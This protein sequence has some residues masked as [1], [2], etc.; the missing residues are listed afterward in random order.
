MTTTLASL[1]RAAQLMPGRNDVH[2]VGEE[3]KRHLVTAT[4]LIETYTG[5]TYDAASQTIVMDSI[6]TLGATSGMSSTEFNKQ[7]YPEYVL[8]VEGAL[9]SLVV[10]DRAEFTYDEE[11]NWDDVDPLVTPDNY[12]YDEDTGTVRLRYR[13]SS[14]VHGMQFSFTKGFAGTSEMLAGQEVLN[15]LS[16]SG[17]DTNLSTP[18]RMLAGVKAKEASDSAS[19]AVGAA[20]AV[21]ITLQPGRET[22]L[23]GLFVY[24]PQDAP[25]VDGDQEFIMTLIGISAGS[26]DTTLSTVTVTTP[27]ALQQFYL[28]GDGDT[29]YEQYRV[30]ISAASPANVIVSYVEYEFA[31]ADQRHMQDTAP[32]NL[33]EACAMLA[34]QLYTR[35]EGGSTGTDE[36]GDRVAVSP[37]TP[38]IRQMLKPYR[39]SGITLV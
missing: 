39:S 35:N 18:G 38:E 17:L 7:P 26:Q 20:E 32:R 36:D 5:K 21:Y 19:V 23:K 24:A 4:M 10:K 13:Q 27:L 2:S 37:M 6:A 3:M 15:L 16:L 8:P 30:T 31:D 1:T 14:R 22:A 25:I 33:S 12:V 11:F 9:S 28:E 34:V 29:I